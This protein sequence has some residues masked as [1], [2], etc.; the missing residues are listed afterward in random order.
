MA[1][2][3]IA[4]LVNRAPVDGT[5]PLFVFDAGYDSV[6]L[7][8]G[9]EN[10]PI[11]VLVRLRSDRCFDADP[12]PT[13]PSP[14]GGRPRKHGAKFTGKDSTPW[15][16]PTA[17]HLTRGGAIWD[18]ARAGVGWAAS[19][20]AGASWP[21]ITQDAAD[22]ARHGGPRR[23]QPLA[24]SVVSTADALALVG[25]SGGSAYPRRTWASLR[26]ALRS[27]TYPALLQ[28]EPGLDDTA[29][30]PPPASRSL[31]LAGRG[32]LHPVALGTAGS[33]RP[34]PAVGAA[35][36]SRQAD[37]VPRPACSFRA[38]A[39]GGHTS[40]SAKTVRTRTRPSQGQP[41]RAGSSL[42][43]VET[44]RLSGAF[45]LA[46]RGSPASAAA[47]CRPVWVTSQAKCVLQNRSGVA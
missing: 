9:L 34:P 41:I 47:A 32:R 36:G 17:E 25:R 1:V 16:S 11:A 38:A 2:A 7:T 40:Q 21:R 8:Q 28:A 37:A 39:D 13:A 6:Q 3:Q 31:D 19:Q 24:G 14:K 45:A 15:P 33:C 29:A 43:G 44:R 18:G 4:G 30:A 5:T 42:S 27:G 20:A 46:H 10:L 12:P 26:A 23:G 22:R 35:A